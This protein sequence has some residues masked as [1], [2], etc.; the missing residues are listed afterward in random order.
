MREASP[1]I[2]RAGARIVMTLCQNREA[3][4]R[5]LERHPTPFPLVIDEDRSLARRWGVHHAFGLDAY[6][7]ARPASFVIDGEGTVRLADVSRTQFQ[8]VAIEEILETL[9]RL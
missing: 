8:S 7:I 4:S 2:E 1:E 9:R 6:N 5:Y 3:V